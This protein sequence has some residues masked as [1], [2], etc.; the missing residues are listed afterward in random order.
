ML[1]SLKGRLGT[2]TTTIIGATGK[3]E[4]WSF[5]RPLDLRFGGKELTHKF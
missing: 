3:E 4:E 5:L 2:K 1:N